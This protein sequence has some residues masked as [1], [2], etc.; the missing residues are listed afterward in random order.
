MLGRASEFSDKC[1]SE[2]FC[3]PLKKEW[4]EWRVRVFS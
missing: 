2:E 3:E 1:L 4:L